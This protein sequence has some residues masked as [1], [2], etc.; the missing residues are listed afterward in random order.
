MEGKRADRI[1]WV[2]GGEGGGMGSMDDWRLGTRLSE[3]MKTWDRSR[4]TTTV[5]YTIVPLR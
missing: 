5:R 1:G 2:G 3:G 4:L